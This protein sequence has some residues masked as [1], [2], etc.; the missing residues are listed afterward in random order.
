ITL[1]GPAGVGKSRLVKEFA[2]SVADE[3]TVLRGR[4]LP[5][6]EGVTFWPLAEV[7]RQITGADSHG[8]IARLLAGDDDADRVDELISQ[9]IG[10]SETGAAGAGTSWAVRKLLEALAR[11]QPVVVVFEDVHWAE[12][13]FL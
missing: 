3:A 7:V 1:L 12:T 5:Y 11:A 13:T 6:G 4:C 2:D 9:A 8:R 10:A